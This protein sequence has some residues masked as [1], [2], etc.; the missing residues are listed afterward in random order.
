M[1]HPRRHSYMPPDKHE[2]LQA[3]SPH[4]LLSIREQSCRKTTLCTLLP[5]KFSHSVVAFDHRYPNDNDYQ[6]KQGRATCQPLT[7]F[8]L[9]FITDGL[10]VHKSRDFHRIPSRVYF[11]FKSTN[12][13]PFPFNL[14]HSPCLGQ[15]KTCSNLFK[16]SEQVMLTVNQF[17]C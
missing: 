6:Y 16:R 12:S 14:G 8:F 4:S 13:S 3:L 5:Y 7:T 17:C 1:L 15:K 10:F 11:Y 9:I 2:C